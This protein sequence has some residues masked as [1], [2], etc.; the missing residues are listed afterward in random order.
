MDQQCTDLSS[1]SPIVRGDFTV[2]LN[3][4]LFF[5]ILQLTCSA[6][7]RYLN[8]AA[9]K[10]GAAKS[11]VPYFMG[12]EVSISISSYRC[13]L[14]CSLECIKFVNYMLVEP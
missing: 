1:L 11:S 4:H 10:W 7:G 2:H 3:L 12:I 6:R 9:H 8:D 5:F 13:S 14:E